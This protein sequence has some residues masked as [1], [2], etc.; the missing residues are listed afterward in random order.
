MPL[1]LGHAGIFAKAGEPAAPTGPSLGFTTGWVDTTN[2]WTT[3]KTFTGFSSSTGKALICM[4]Y[5]NNVTQASAP[6]ATI[7]YSASGAIVTNRFRTCDVDGQGAGIYIGTVNGGAT[8]AA[9]ITVAFPTN[10]GNILLRAWEILGSWSGNV[11]LCTGDTFQGSSTSVALSSIVT[12]GA[13]KPIVAFGGG[14]RGDCIP[15]S[16]D[17]PS[18]WN[19]VA[20]MTT[21]S[22]G[23]TGESSGEFYTRDNLALGASAAFT[24]TLTTATFYRGAGIVELL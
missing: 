16:I 18:L 19:A 6:L 21:L 20:E 8:G 9:D 10:C 24:M 2:G 22:G 7:G 13:N 11:G 12:Q 3:A 23:A 14:S 15:M 1:L 5:R 4:Y 17:N